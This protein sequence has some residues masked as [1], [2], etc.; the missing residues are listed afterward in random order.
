MNCAYFPFNLKFHHPFTISKGT[1]THQP[2]LIVELES[3]G[4]KGYGEA[5]AITYYNITVEKMM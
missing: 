2:T 4:K 5:P 1:K 3:F